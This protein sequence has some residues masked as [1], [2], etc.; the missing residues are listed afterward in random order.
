MIKCNIYFSDLLREGLQ[1]VEDLSWVHNEQA[2]KA[3]YDRV[4]REEL[5][6]LTSTEVKCMTNSKGLPRQGVQG[7]AERLTIAGVKCMRNSE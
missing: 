6:R 3:Y 4:C 5:E 1:P 2:V 7:G